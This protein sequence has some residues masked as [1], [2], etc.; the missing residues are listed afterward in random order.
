MKDTSVDV[1]CFVG[2]GLNYFA[3]VDANFAS[4]DTGCTKYK[5]IAMRL[6]FLALLLKFD[7]LYLKN[8]NLESIIILSAKFILIF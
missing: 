3:G 4:N 2:G 7:I 8:Y 5:V 1:C 6:E